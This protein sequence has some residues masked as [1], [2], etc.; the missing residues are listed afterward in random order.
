[1]DFQMMAFIAQQY[2]LLAVIILA[3]YG[4]GSPISRW[5]FRAIPGSAVLTNSLQLAGGIGVSMVCLFVLG[6][7]GLFNSI[8]ITILLISGLMLF[9]YQLVTG[10]P[11]PGAIPVKPIDR[12]RRYSI[13]FLLPASLVA[14]F[15]L[16]YLLLP[17][18]M[19][20]AWDE[21]MYHLPYARHWADNGSLVINEWVRYPLFPY[22][23]GLLYAGALVFDNET[24]THLLHA[25]TGALTC[26][27]IFG[28]AKRFFNLPVAVIATLL[29][30]DATRWGWDQAYVDLTLMYF[31]VCALLCLFLR[32]ENGDKRFSFLAAFMLA[33]AVGIKYQALMYLPVFLVL[34]LFIE[35]RVSVIIQSALVFVVFGSYWYI[36][37]ILISG[38]P[39]HPMGAEFFGYWL[40][41]SADL[42]AQMEDIDRVRDLPEWYFIIGL[43]TVFYWRSMSQLSKM[44]LISTAAS[45]VLWYLLAGYTR[46]L[47]P[48]YPFLAILAADFL[49]KLWVTLSKHLPAVR[50]GEKMKFMFK[51]ASLAML[52]LVAVVVAVRE[53]EDSLSKIAPNEVARHEF[54]KNEFSGYALMSTLEQELDGPLYQFGFEGEVYLLG[55][56][57]RGDIFGPGRY[58]DVYPLTGDAVLLSEH[59]KSLGA[60]YFLVN[61]QRSPFS[62]IV[63]DPSLLNRFSIL[64]SSDSA[65]LYYIN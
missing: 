42:Q 21:L 62:E 51:N 3:F 7:V 8:A 11:R 26:M 50:V 5:M 64:E 49:V 12:S 29:V 13:T 24:L 9:G 63:W 38:D 61:K 56:D 17:L 14:V 58:T 15:V 32:F 40:W 39:I 31:W 27:A 46:Y 65:V 18:Q 41:N 16:P 48:V 60:Q 54:L 53:S 37:N 52:L 35:R 2:L 55:K 6:S 23:M 25:L 44:L 57:V 43:G 1:M 47:T 28:A 20:H 34:A 36:K 19:P 4:L 33:M 59:L 45:L 30:F 10:F 22:N